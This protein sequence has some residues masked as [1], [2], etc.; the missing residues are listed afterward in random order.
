M[1]GIQA[2]KPVVALAE[3]KP[4]AVGAVEADKPPVNAGTGRA[5]PGPN[6]AVLDSGVSLHTDL[7]RAG[8]INCLTTGTEADGDGHGTGVSGVLGAIDNDTGILG[9]APGVPIYSA[10]VLGDDLQGTVQTLMCG[11]EWVSQNAVRYDIA[12]VNMSISYPGADDGNCGYTNGDTIHQAICSLTRDGISI[13]AGAGNSAKDLA[14]TSPSNFD[15]VLAVTNMADYDGRPGSLAASP[16][17]DTT[18]DD[19]YVA[20]SNFAVSAADQ[21][22]TVAA[23][24]ACPYT[25]KKGNRYGYVA[26]GTS[27]ATAAASGVVVGVLRVR[28]LRRQVERRGHLDHQGAGVDGGDARSRLHRG[29]D[30]AGR[31]PVLRAPRVGRAGGLPDPD[32]DPDP[33]THTDADP[34]SDA[35]PDTHTDTRPHGADGRDHVAGLGRHGLR[36]IRGRHRGRER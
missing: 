6:V 16:C 5:W 27:M 2:E 4:P 32:P 22:H 33:D 21:A 11:L 14:G 3:T 24:G 10:R 17:A 9:I 29:P 23:P 20:K 15:E 36:G 19:T 13:V 34:D 26:S 28:T 1:L 12:V 8:A 31:R 30:S 18:K 35:D 7:N 25:T